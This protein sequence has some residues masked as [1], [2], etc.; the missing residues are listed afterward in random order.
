MAGQ[1]VGTAGMMFFTPPALSSGLA[2]GRYLLGKSILGQ[3]SQSRQR[4]RRSILK[5]VGP[6]VVLHEGTL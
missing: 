1:Y 4:F 6:F 2:A 3:Q 5:H